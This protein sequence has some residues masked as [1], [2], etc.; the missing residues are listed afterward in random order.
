MH[1]DEP[2]AGWKRPSVQSR[3]AAA[4]AA[5]VD[6]EKVPGRHGVHATGSVSPRPVWKEPAAHEVH[7]EAA[8]LD[9]YCP[10]SQGAHAEAADAP[11][12]AE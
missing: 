8:E 5:P 7:E 3:Q 10:A 12:A 6:V 11:S 2:A 1:A 9:P 4:A